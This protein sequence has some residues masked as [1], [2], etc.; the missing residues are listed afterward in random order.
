[1]N[2]PLHKK[3]LRVL[4]RHRR[5]VLS[6]Q[7]QTYV[8]QAVCNNTITLH[9][10]KASQNLAFYRAYD[11]EVSIDNILIKSQK[12]GKNCYLP[13]LHSH[14]QRL[15]FYSYLLENPLIQNRFNIEEPNISRENPTSL[16][17]LDLIFLPLVAFDEKGNRL[18]YGAG[19]YDRTLAPLKGKDSKNPLLV[20]IAYE[21]QKIDKIPFGKW[22]I[23]LNLVITEKT[24]YQF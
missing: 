1:M 9:S 11:G 6:L 13:V 10:F 16:A 18:G 7:E 4:M 12:M 20:G 5:N 3:E 23:P 17:D 22:D 14:Q 15:N 2:S 8:A 19:Y 24:I 21:F